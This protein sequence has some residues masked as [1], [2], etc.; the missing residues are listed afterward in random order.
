MS[1]T[2]III[3]PVPVPVFEAKPKWW[4]RARSDPAPQRER[5]SDPSWP[6]KQEIPTEETR[7]LLDGARREIAE[8]REQRAL[9][10]LMP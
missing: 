1:V 5:K 3:L 10:E 8:R 2:Q 4:Q 6:K 7:R 9:R